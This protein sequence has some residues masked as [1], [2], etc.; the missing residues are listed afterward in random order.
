VAAPRPRPNRDAYLS[1]ENRGGPAFTV[2]IGDV[3]VATL[4][5]DSAELLRPGEDGLP[6]LPW[7][8]SLVRVLGEFPLLREQVAVLPRWYVQLGDESLGLSDQVVLG[9]IPPPCPPEI[10]RESAIELAAGHTNLTTLVSARAGRFGELNTSPGLGSGHP[11]PL[12][13]LVWAIT[14]SGDVEI[15]PPSPSECFT[16]P[17]EAT[18]FLD[19]ETGGYRT[20]QVYSPSS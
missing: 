11:I 19:Y 5:C 6:E 10:S 3:Q 2:R 15:C 18:V 17:G 20:T 14:Y 13:A 16:R 4:R 12:D 1:L 7:D 8:L 9:P